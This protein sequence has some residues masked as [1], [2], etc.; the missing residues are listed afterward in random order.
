[1]KRWESRPNA[2]AEAVV[3][4]MHTTQMEK[5]RRLPRL[6][7]GWPG[8]RPSNG[9]SRS[10]EAHGPVGSL[11][12]RRPAPAGPCREKGSPGQRLGRRRHA[13]ASV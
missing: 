13:C 7:E 11:A 8:L 2:E 3:T 1:V 4:K 9:A 12:R 6:E 5:F 10:E